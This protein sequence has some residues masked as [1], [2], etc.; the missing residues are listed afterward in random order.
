MNGFMRSEFGRI[1]EMGSHEE[2]MALRGRYAHLFELQIAPTYQFSFNGL[3]NQ[4]FGG[5]RLAILLGGG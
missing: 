2:R 4:R 3:T 5:V 1:I